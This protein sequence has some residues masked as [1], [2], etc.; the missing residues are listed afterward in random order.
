MTQPGPDALR[1]WPRHRID[2]RLKVSFGEG[3]NGQTVFGRA[4]TL[5]E[6]GLSAF[7]PC[8]IPIGAT[9]VLEVNFPYSPTEVKVKAIVRSCEG[10]RYG[11]EFVNVPDQVRAAIVKNCDAAEATP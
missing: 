5:S 8:A 2:A 11:L 7:I 6:G 10:F 3:N 1:R 9:V 4:N